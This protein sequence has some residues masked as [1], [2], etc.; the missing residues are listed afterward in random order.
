MN[1]II[2]I[3]FA[4]CF[5]SSA[6]KITAK[7]LNREFYDTDIAVERSVGMPIREIFKVHNE[8]FFRDAENEAI[9]TATK[10]ENAVI[11]CGG[12]SVLSEF[13]PELAKSGTVVWLKAEA[14]TVFDRLNGRT[15]PL[16]DDLTLNELAVKLEERSSL[17]AKYADVVVSTDGEYSKKVAELVISVLKEKGAVK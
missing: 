13:F 1:N 4:A 15:R 3:G 10:K 7:K 14:K 16:Y 2:F 6:G 17:Y 12:G 5:K 9:K 8:K 11:S